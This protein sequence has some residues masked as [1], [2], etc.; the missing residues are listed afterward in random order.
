LPRPPWSR[1][2]GDRRQKR[3]QPGYCLA[4]GLP[5]TPAARFPRRRF[6]YVSAVYGMAH[7]RASHYMH[8]DNRPLSPH[9]M[10][11]K[12]QMQTV[13]SGIHR[14]GGLLLC[15]GMVFLVIWLV[16]VAAGPES[17]QTAQAWVGSIIGRLA[18][19]V[20]TLTLFFHL[21][22]G[23]RHLMWDF[24]VGLEIETVLKTGYVA[25]FAAIGLTLLAWVLA[26]TIGGA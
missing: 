23:I 11:Y 17:F 12:L 2:K 4:A 22:T 7:C 25:I 19:F 1:H 16:A 10:I 3:A 24:G 15:L 5:A 18:L 9:L 13:L 6:D 20:F 21:C 26:Y 8:T 14:G